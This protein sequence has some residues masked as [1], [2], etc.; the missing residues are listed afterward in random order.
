MIIQ[1]V[2]KKSKGNKSERCQK[3]D[4]NWT[5]ETEAQMCSAQSDLAN[6]DAVA[7]AEADAEDDEQHYS[8]DFVGDTTFQHCVVCPA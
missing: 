1:L 6:F 2:A 7:V 3:G 8:V 4:L 5:S